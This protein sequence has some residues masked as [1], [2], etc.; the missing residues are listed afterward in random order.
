MIKTKISLR[1]VALIVVASILLPVQSY[2]CG[3]QGAAVNSDGS[4]I[5]GTGTISTSWNSKK[6][7]PRN[8]EYRLDLGS[9]VCGEKVT[10]Y[11]DG[12]QSQTI[13]VDGWVNVSFRRR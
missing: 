5:D 2:A 10:V 3:I 4:K 13:R 7:Y 9:S 8:G 11:L 1:N 12:N 6:A